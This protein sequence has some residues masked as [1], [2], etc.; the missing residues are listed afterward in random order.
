[1]QLLDTLVEDYASLSSVLAAFVQHLQG[2]PEQQHLPCAHRVVSELVRDGFAEVLLET[3]SQ[4]RKGRRDLRVLEGAERTRAV[5]PESL[6]WRGPAQ[7]HDVV[8]GATPKG[9]RA[10]IEG[11]F[12]NI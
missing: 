6:Y 3:V 11:T 8:V 1:M 2:G 4:A 9:E 12:S 5:A 7:G 10:L